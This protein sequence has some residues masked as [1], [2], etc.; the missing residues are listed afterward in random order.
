[1]RV[2]AHVQADTISAAVKQVF[3]VLLV[4]LNHSDVGFVPRNFSSAHHKSNQSSENY[5][6]AYNHKVLYLLRR[7]RIVSIIPAIAEKVIQNCLLVISGFA[8]I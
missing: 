5:T 3:N 4:G 1:M 7:G 6:K 2:A 8:Y